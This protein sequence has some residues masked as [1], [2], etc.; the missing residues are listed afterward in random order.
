MEA[1][2]TTFARYLKPEI[3]ALDEFGY[4]SFTV[5]ASGHLFRLVSARHQMKA[6]IV[7]A[8]NT[9]FTHWRRFFPSE[10]QSVATVDRLIDRATI[11]RFSGQPCR[12]PKE[13]VGADPD[14]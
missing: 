6:S 8:A 14:A 13:I 11:L 12:K 7:V 5:D 2:I 3:L 10:A 1:I 4:A 9:G